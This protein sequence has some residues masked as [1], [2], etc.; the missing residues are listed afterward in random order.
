MHGWSARVTH[1]LEPTRPDV[2]SPRANEAWPVAYG[3][4]LGEEPGAVVEDPRLRIGDGRRRA[5]IEDVTPSIDAGRFPVKR[6]VGDRVRVEADAFADGHDV[7]IAHL[8]HRPPGEDSWLEVPMTGPDNDRWWAEFTVE[9]QG[10]HRFTV[11]AWVDRFATWLRDLRRRIDAGQ[12]VAV[13]L[14]IG[15]ELIETA[16]GR[17]AE[18]GEK[19]GA[20]RLSAWAAELRGPTAD[21][22]RALDA[23]L[24]AVARAHTPRR[25]ATLHPELEIVVDR[26]R[27]A[28]SAWYELFPRSASPDPSR[29]GTLRDVIARLPYIAG[30]GFD[31][32]YLPPI[33]PI[34][35]EF[36]K[37]PN[38]RTESG[39]GDPG[40]PWAIGSVE[41]GHRD[42]HSELGTLDD[43]RALVAAAREHGMEVA[44][45]I[46]FQAAPD[47][48]LVRTH[49]EW[50]RRRPDGT[51]Q[52]AENPP[53]KYQDIV[54]FDFESDAWREMWIDLRDTIAFWVDEGVEIF[55]VDNPHTKAFPFW[56]WAIATLKAR[57]PQVL[58]LAE[59]FTRPKVMYRLAK[60]GF[61]QSYTYFTWRNE[62]HELIEY[63]TE[64]CHN[65]PR[66]FFRPN[67]WPNTPDILHEVLQ[68]GGRP[69]FEARAILAATLTANWGIYGPTFELGEHVPREAASEEYLDSEKYQQ[70]TWDLDRADTL[71][72]LLARLNTVRR[73]HPAFQRNDW[74][75]FHPV[76][77]DQI[78]AYSKRTTDGRDAV[79]VIV[80]F[81]PKAPQ[82]GRLEL[83]LEEFGLSPGAPFDAVDLLTGTV[84]RWESAERAIEI[85]PAVAIGRVLQFR[86]PRRTAR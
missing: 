21:S 28:F 17:A 32:L 14:L 54:P 72:P 15:A 51:I 79:F 13:D 68:T 12:D 18:T 58:F 5:V 26:E 74:L 29:H 61:S 10:R 82:A 1:G 6:I 11:Q 55:R 44:L 69:M 63:M 86:A 59:A 2:E 67:F 81:D 31:V 43:V 24:A 16:A 37:G 64:L 53:K 38:N 75:R 30:M 22:E 80:S 56:E 62:K 70:R 9:R 19:A 76:D 50:F 3:I 39:P 48:P 20:A 8:L 33:H 34:G 57:Y 78:V 36:R 66:E 77:N 83:A 7:V 40:S 84:E 23:E 52:Y 85:D 65:E 49:E 25:F 4:D 47:H 41:G 45:D 42:V 60:L 35:R 71:A 27:A 46:A 73:A